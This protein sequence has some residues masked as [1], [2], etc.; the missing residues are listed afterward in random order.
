ME[1]AQDDDQETLKCCGCGAEALTAC[2]TAPGAAQPAAKAAQTKIIETEQRAHVVSDDQ[3]QVWSHLR[4]VFGLAY[5]MWLTRN[6][7]IW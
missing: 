3:F 4:T 2:G 7:R 1:Q 6:Y 5:R